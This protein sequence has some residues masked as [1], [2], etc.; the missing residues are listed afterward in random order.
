MWHSIARAVALPIPILIIGHFDSFRWHQHILHDDFDNVLVDGEDPLFAN[1]GTAL[2]EKRIDRR[3]LKKALEILR[4]LVHRLSCFLVLVE[5]LGMLLRHM[6][7]NVVSSEALLP[8]LVVCSLLPLSSA[9][10]KLLVSTFSNPA[11]AKAAYTGFH[12]T[13]ILISRGDPQAK[14]FLV[15]HLVWIHP[16]RL[17][18]ITRC[19]LLYTILWRMIKILQIFHFLWAANGCTELP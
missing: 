5:L 4:R 7:A 8:V 17:L 9:R 1:D 13:G 18:L 3:L 11:L 10:L 19:H 2:L 15:L 6:T 12:C 16:T 14:E